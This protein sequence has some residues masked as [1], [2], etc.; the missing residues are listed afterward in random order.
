MLHDVPCVGFQGQVKGFA[1]CPVHVA[2][3]GRK[4]CNNACVRATNSK[5][6]A[7]SVEFVAF[8]VLVMFVALVEFASSSRCR[9]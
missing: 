4:Q 1:R 8:V 6:M 7:A 5:P 3:V 9:R 2:S